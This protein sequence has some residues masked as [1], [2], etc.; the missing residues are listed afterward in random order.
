M[1]GLLINGSAFSAADSQAEYQKLQAHLERENNSA[2]KGRLMLKLAGWHLNQSIQ[3]SREGDLQ[4]VDK[5]LVQFADWVKDAQNHFRQEF[6]RDP[7]KSQNIFRQAEMQLNKQIKLLE[8]LKTNYSFDQ[9]Q[10]ISQAIGVA[11]NTREDLLSYLF[12]EENVRGPA[13]S[14]KSQN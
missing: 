2:E 4:K 8:N 3:E 13:N 9:Q 10:I 11:Q 14:R 1:V 12:G 7:K 6:A 5:T